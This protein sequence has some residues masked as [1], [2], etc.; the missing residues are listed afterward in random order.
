MPKPL[1]ISVN[2]VMAMVSFTCW[3]FL[4]LVA[5]AIHPSSQSVHTTYLIR[6][7]TSI[8]CPPSTAD[9]CL[10]LQEF[11][12]EEEQ[13]RNTT[14]DITLEFMSGVH[15]LSTTIEIYNLENITALPLPG[16]DVLVRCITPASL[17]FGNISHLQISQ[18][19]IDSCGMGLLLGTVNL[20]ATNHAQFSHITI[21]N[22][23]GSAISVEYSYLVLNS[24]VIDHC[25]FSNENAGFGGAVSAQYSQLSIVGMSVFSKNI[26]QYG[27]AI[28]IWHGSFEISGNITFLQNVA[29]QGGALYIEMA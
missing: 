6:P 15:N 13:E 23:N 10:T 19:S 8:P 29:D 5:V 9:R 7:N 16:S 3:L 14:T 20:N 25:G 22:S 12:E 2:V 26:A 11:A 28:F 1:L 24:T 21:V 17:Y 4:L 18:L 27:G